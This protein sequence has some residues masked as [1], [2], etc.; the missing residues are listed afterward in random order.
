MFSESTTLAALSEGL[1]VREDVKNLVDLKGESLL[2]ADDVRGAY[3]D[4]FGDQSSP[5]HP[6]IFPVIRR[7]I[8]NIEGHDLYGILATLGAGG[9]RET[10][11]EEELYGAAHDARSRREG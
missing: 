1:V 11:G 7:A 6:T 9:D 8:A 5:R 10:G 2:Y 4:Q 3:T